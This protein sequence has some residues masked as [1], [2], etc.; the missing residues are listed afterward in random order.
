MAQGRYRESNVDVTSSNCL[1]GAYAA[2]AAMPCLGFQV[3]L[4]WYNVVR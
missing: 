1:A 4:R 3:R 2:T